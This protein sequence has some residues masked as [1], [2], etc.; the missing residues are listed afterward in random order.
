MQLFISLIFTIGIFFWVGDC[1]ACQSLVSFPQCLESLLGILEMMQSNPSLFTH[2]NSEASKN[3]GVLQS[4]Q[5]IR[6]GTG[7]SSPHSQCCP[8]SQTKAQFRVLPRTC[9]GNGRG[10]NSPEVSISITQIMSELSKHP[11]TTTM[12]SIRN[13]GAT[14]MLSPSFLL[15]TLM[16]VKSPG[17]KRQAYR[18]ETLG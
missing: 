12:P 14:I 18:W 6:T 3:S 8:S 9:G 11:T 10:F 16:R 13:S 4:L 7:H 5:L 17:H 1:I 2:E 15:A